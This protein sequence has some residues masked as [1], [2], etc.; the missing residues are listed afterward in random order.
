MSVDNTLGL[1]HDWPSSSEICSEAARLRRDRS[2]VQEVLR[3]TVNLRS[4]YHVS[5]IAKL[6]EEL[7]LVPLP[8]SSPCSNWLKDPLKLRSTVPDALISTPTC[9]GRR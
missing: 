5:A 2:T 1:F 7:L 6:E 3:P 9:S 8:R 4:P